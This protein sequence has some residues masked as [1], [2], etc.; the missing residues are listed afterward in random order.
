[1]T[2]ATDRAIT[3]GTRERRR[4]RGGEF[5]GTTAGLAAGN[6]QANLVILP[7]TLA[8]DFLRFA[9]A[10][11][12]PCPVL[13]VAEPGDPH[14]PTLGGDLDI[15]TDLPKY[16]VWRD[17]EL[18]EEPTEIHA[19][20]RDDLV[21]FALGCS[22]S[23]EQALI[24]EGIELRHMTCGSNVPMYR[25]NIRCVPA[26]SFAGPLVVSMRPLTPVDAIR[27]VQ[28]TSRFPSVHGAPVHIGLPHAIGISDL[29][30]PDYGDAVPVHDGELPV[31]WA[32]G[33]T[34]Q[35]V[36]AEALPE[37]CITHAPGSMLITDLLNAKLASL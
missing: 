9:Q 16:R 35:A 5:S 18:V 8:H 10:N 2:A 36:V 29:G 37:F 20:W 13:A 34:P 31:F 19:L 28:I 17:G 26:G 25:T 4:I 6:V 32:C 14:L 3:V 23:F 24:E 11:P 22:F 12:K 15:R 30:H 7:K 33:V 27:A 1:M 21:S